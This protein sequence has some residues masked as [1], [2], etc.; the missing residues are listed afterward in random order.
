MGATEEKH[1]NNRA[2]LQSCLDRKEWHEFLLQAN[3]I[4]KS[5]RVD[6]LLTPPDDAPGYIKKACDDFGNRKAPNKM[7]Q[8]EMF[9][10]SEESAA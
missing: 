3:K 4:W 5:T 6:Y 7:D 1:I 10:D 9:V 2:V 8:V